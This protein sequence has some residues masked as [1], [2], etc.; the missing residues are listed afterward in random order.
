MKECGLRYPGFCLCHH[1][2][3]SKFALTL[4]PE[5]RLLPEQGYRNPIFCCSAYAVARFTRYHQLSGSLC[6]PYSW[7]R[8]G[9]KVRCVDNDSSLLPSLTLLWAVI[10]CYAVLWSPEVPLVNIAFTS[11]DFSVHT[12]SNLFS[13]RISLVLV[14]PVG[15]EPT[16][17][18]L[19]THVMTTST[20][21]ALYCY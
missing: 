13:F 17:W 21:V 12:L 11:D 8:A 16:C 19:Q 6:S 2:S 1:P 18:V 10:T 14:Q 20:K 4:K 5:T 15:I 3:R 7:P 9:F